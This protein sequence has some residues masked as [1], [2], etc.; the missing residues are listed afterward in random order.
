MNSETSNKILIITNIPTPYRIPLFNELASQ[1][2]KRQLKL[3]V[4]FGAMGYSRRKWE[5]DISAC[6]FD[7]KILS[8]KKIQLLDQEKVIFTYDG[9][10]KTI[11][12]EHPIVIFSAGFSFATTK[13]WLR[14]WLKK[15][16]YIIWSGAINT[17]DRLNP[18]FR[19]IHRKLLIKRAIGFVAYGKKA[20]EYLISLGA[21]PEKISIAINT[22]DIDFFKNEINSNKYNISKYP[23]K[24]LLY[25]G[26][27]TKGKR[28]DLILLV[29]KELSTHRKD[30]VL[31]L[32]GD[33]S[34]K[35][36]LK[37]LAEKLKIIEFMSF[38]G[39]KQREEIVKYY[40]EADC[41]LFPSEYD[42]WGLVL[43][44]AMA[45]GL[46]CLASIYAGATYDLI[47]DGINGFSVNFS[48]TEKVVENVN[49]ILDNSEQAKIIGQKAR[50]TISEIGSLEKSARA[51][52]DAIYL[53]KK[54]L[55]L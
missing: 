37:R 5:I 42:I 36:Y 19:K 44:E 27:L 51:F 41:F 7:Y 2:E 45:A 49:W 54:G 10:F 15:T 28:I 31:K 53:T 47:E 38:E 52:I 11:R 43:N 3:K 4:I 16:P 13:L 48:E 55:I 46:P 22:V 18:R 24:C 25:V 30:F 8:S 20:K 35:K 17:S 9:L 21:A 1:L 14:S 26:N 23:V 32:V 29:I 12:R 33:G 34:E 6:R 50:N 40:A 39:F